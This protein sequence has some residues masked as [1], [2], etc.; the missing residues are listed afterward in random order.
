MSYDKFHSKSDDIFR[1][2]TID[3]AL[4]VSSSLVGITLPAL[5]PAMEDNFPEVVDKVRMI[6]QGRQLITHGQQ[7]YYTEHFAYAEPSL[8]KIFD[9]ELINGNTEKALEQPNTVI[10]SESMAKRTFGDEDPIGKRV[11]IGNQTGLEV[12]ALMKDI[13]ENSHLNFDVIVSMVQA[14]TA[15]GFAQF[16]RSWQS[17]SMVTYVQLN[18]PS[19]EESVEAKMEP[20]I[21]ENNVG[22]NFK[23]TLQPLGDIH[24]KS[25]DVLFENYNLNKTDIGYVFTLAAV[26]VFVI[27]IASFNFMN[28]ST[29]RSANRAQEVGIRK[30]FGAIRS[31][32]INQFMIEAVL[33]A[34]VSLII[35]LVFVAS[36]GS[37]VNLPFEKNLAT[38]FISN[39]IWLTGAILFT[40]LLGL[41]SGSYPA[42]LLS[43]YSPTSILRGTF[44]T[45]SQGVIL[46]KGLVIF[47]F[48]I[49]IV[50]IIG[51][52][53]VYEQLQL[54]RNADK[55][56]DTEQIVTLN[57]GHPSLQQ[58][59]PVLKN[60]LEQEP[61]ILSTAR[62]QGMP[63]RTFG[64]RGVTPEGAGPDDTWIVSV[65][66]FDEEFL[67]LMGMEIADGR[68]FDRDIQ[69]DPQQSILINEAM[70]TE[71]AWDDPV[72]RK[73]TFGQNERTIIGVVKNFHFASMRHK[74]EPLAMF[75]NPN[76]G[77][78]LAIKFSAENA[79]EAMEFVQTSWNEVF[80]NSPIEYRFFDEEFG[81][82]YE[83]DEKFGR[84]VFSFTWLAIFIACLGLFG[85]SA[86]TAEQKT[87]EIGV[88]KVLGASVSGIVMLLSREFTKL[89]IVAVVIASP[90]AYYMMKIWLGD[91]AYRVNIGWFWFVVSAVMALMI[92]L[93]TVS[94]Q[95]V[96]AAMANP[97]NS[98]R[99]E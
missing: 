85:L 52:T 12:T 19:S 72:G 35:A 81:Q 89:I 55:G 17:I 9:F 71:L 62:T 97:V 32:L 75:F 4:G 80:P 2:L 27:L 43:K 88:R 18:D 3:E 54:M 57:I 33:I 77:G 29:A 86:F 94:F 37:F 59:I 34:L 22:E 66:T 41:F 53:I 60:K 7:G 47:Q 58:S 23:V 90:L 56:F 50:M 91:F 15:S 69:T 61:S 20:L 8:F 95:S 24:L 82:Q 26:G 1:V 44:K 6:P 96:K 25:K 13:N 68:A 45:S 76:G 48:T 11:D 28:L 67:D 78:N 65:L 49:S 64:R 99:Y 40:V 92:A 83:S 46:R 84:L 38:F 63:G 14:D 73:I 51:T 10:F 36:L 30:V 21:R 98:L 39:P 42:L 93:M 31:Q 74:I 79:S 5:G 70:A 87:K 16:L